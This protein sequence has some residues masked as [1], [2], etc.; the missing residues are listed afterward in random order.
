LEGLGQYIFFLTNYFLGWLEFQITLNNSKNYRQIMKEIIEK[1]KQLTGKE[2]VQLTERGNKAIMLALA[3]AKQLGKTTVL[4]PD[5]GGWLTFKNYPGKL[6]LK[7]KEIKTSH[8]L[9]SLEDLEKKADNDSALLACSMPG[10]LAVETCLK[11]IH[12]VCRKK[13]MLFIND[14]SGSIGTE[15]AKCGDLIVSS[16]GKWKPVNLEYGGFV[17]TNDNEH[18]TNFDESYFEE[19][20]QEKLLEKLEQLPERLKKL[21][22]ARDKILD[23]LQSF[24]IIHKD[25]QGINI[26]VRFDDEEAKNRITDYCRQNRLEFTECPRYIRVNEKAVSIEVKRL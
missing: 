14:A 9:L 15:A 7:L 2:Y 11:K 16:F 10:Y 24:D 5:Q 20:K 18:Y 6:N 4:I 12:D 21:K 22:E 3:L 25:K 8:G 23:E 26:A 19:E 13:N 1:L 17:A